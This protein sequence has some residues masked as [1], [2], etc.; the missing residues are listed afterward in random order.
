M[1]QGRSVMT[2]L[3]RILFLLVA[4]AASAPD[5]TQTARNRMVDEQIVA[6]GIGDPA[7]LAAMRKVPRHQFVPPEQA[8]FAYE[9]NALP[10]GFGQTISQPA[11][12]AQMT[13]LAGLRPGQRVLEIGTGSGYQAAVLAAMGADVYTIE[14]VEPLGKRAAADLARLGYRAV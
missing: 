10:I 12:V 2:S 13:E 5:P 7:V 14:I 4:T 3:A 1:L 9:D 6:R 11:V 8:P